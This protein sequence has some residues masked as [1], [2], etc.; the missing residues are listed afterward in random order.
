ALFLPALLH[1][2]SFELRAEVRWGPQ[3]KEKVFTLSA[4]EGL[5]SHTPDFGVYTPREVSNFAENFRNNVAGWTLDDDP[6]PIAV[7][8]TTWVPDFT[9]TH[10]KTGK[11]VYVEVLGFWRKLNMEEHYKRLKRALPG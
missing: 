10:A 2:K 11:E 1:C 3:K 4:S 6:H 8:G 5:R 9:L 7:E